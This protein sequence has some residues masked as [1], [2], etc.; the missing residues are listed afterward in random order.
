METTFNLVPY[1]RDL[2]VKAVPENSSSVGHCVLKGWL[3]ELGNTIGFDSMRLY[4]YNDKGDNIIIN[5]IT[6]VNDPERLKQRALDAAH[7]NG[8]IFKTRQQERSFQYDFVS[9]IHK[10]KNQYYVEH[11]T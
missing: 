5:L 7:T 9:Q 1:Y 2:L 8:L 10:T 4:L 11:S 3:H 6:Q